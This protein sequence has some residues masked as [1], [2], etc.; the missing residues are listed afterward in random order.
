MNQTPPSRSLFVGIAAAAA[1]VIV[2]EIGLTRLFSYTIW[3]H[4]AYLTISVALLGFGASGSMLAAFPVL[5]RR[6]GLLSQFSILAQLGVLGCLIV[7]SQLPLDPLRIDTDPQQALRVLAYY[8]AV[9]F[10]FLMGGFLIAIPLDRHAEVVGRLYFWD[11]VGAG[12]ACAA[13]VP[14]I[15]WIGT[16]AVVASSS[17][18][19][20]LAGAAYGPRG[21]RARYGALGLSISFVVLGVSGFVE[22]VPAPEKH[23]AK[24][25][26]KPN[27]NIVYNRWTP[28]NRVDVVRFDPPRTDGSYIEWGISPYYKGGAPG[29]YMI[30]NDGDSCAVMYNWDGKLESLDFLD[31]HVLRTPYVVLDKPKVLAIGLGGGADV[32]NA[33]K[34]DAAS[35]VG[36][37]LNPM[38]I[39][40]GRD[41]MRDFNGNLLNH[42]KVEVV[43]AEGRSFLRSRR[44]RYDLIEINSVDTLSALTTGAYVLSESYLYTVEA[45]DDYLDHLRPGGVFAMAVGDYVTDTEPA[46]HVI[47]LALIVR[48]ALRKRGIKDIAAHVAILGSAGTLPFTH[49]LVKN[50]PFTDAEVYALEDFAG[51]EGFHFYHHPKG[52]PGRV[53]SLIL[54]WS[55][56]DNERFIATTPYNFTPATD[57]SP[58]FFNF[59][60]WRDLLNPATYSALHYSRTLA[61]G[62]VVLGV[63]LLQSIV[64]SALLIL[65]PLSRVPRPAGAGRARRAAFL[66]Y[67]ASLGLGFILLEISFI[68][69]FVLFLGYPTYAL[70]VVM[71][72]LL[73]STGV[74]SLA[75]VG[76]RDHV[77]A[78][79]RRLAWLVSLAGAYLVM[80]PHVFERFLGAGLAVRI[81]ISVALIAPLGFVLGS[82]FPLGIRIVSRHSPRLVPWAWAVNG[83]CTVVGTL[84]SVA[85]A[86]QWGFTVVAMSAL[87]IYAFGVLSMYLAC[88]RGERDAAPA[89]DTECVSDTSTL[90]DP[91]FDEG[92]RGSA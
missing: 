79:P 36:V 84:V 66:F 47:R 53:P 2:L 1:A 41:L 91:S 75:T 17:L 86:M 15:W 32:L 67:F 89:E 56:R 26:R 37:E 64:F 61:T 48:Q 31:H 23:V 11:M 92:V 82:F 57:D 83:C 68:Q 77:Q 62:Q 73:T 43:A 30:G 39:H 65:W 6:E 4:F 54:N 38:T 3:Y 9:A 88:R 70:T 49:T 72:S 18:L 22:F 52:K 13:V 12:L 16:P 42:P 33:L 24:F 76:V 7:I 29:F 34:H 8:G 44:E 50:E 10:P 40:V 81:A 80:V 25:Q 14:M 5:R 58:F 69:R 46:R 21:S 74:G 78:L 20:A 27:A 35:I 87:T 45:I 28:V 60:R 71:L 59:Y 63:M 85:A 55:D 90:A 19:F 51:K